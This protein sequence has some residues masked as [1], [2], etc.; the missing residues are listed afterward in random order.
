[1]LARAR[2]RRAKANSPWT[3]ADLV[4]SAH[5]GEVKL[6]SARVALADLPGHAK[7]PVLTATAS[8]VVLTDRLHASFTLAVD[9]LAMPDLSSYWPEGIGEDSRGWL[10]Q[11]LIGGAA[12]TRMW[13][14][15]WTAG[16][17]FPTRS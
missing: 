8:A 11:N 7:P 3:S 4:L 15:L 1:M 9:S 17:I 6:D 10:V 2:W 5:P 14:A 13:K 16:G 12:V